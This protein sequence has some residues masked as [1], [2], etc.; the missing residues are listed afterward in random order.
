MG[1]FHDCFA[2]FTEFTA[3]FVFQR[4]D[5][6]DSERGEA[7]IEEETEKGGLR[8]SCDDDDDGAVVSR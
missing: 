1:F 8:S 4:L 3:Y 2:G 7:Y 6:G 5:S